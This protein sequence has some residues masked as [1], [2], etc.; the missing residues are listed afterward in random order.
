MRSLALPLIP[1]GFIP[2]RQ[3]LPSA[4]C[5]RVTGHQ[6]ALWQEHSLL[7]TPC[8]PLGVEARLISF[9]EWARREEQ[10]EGRKPVCI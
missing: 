10:T 7:Q 5:W 8:P 1:K 3:V 2:K 4:C 6:G 9:L